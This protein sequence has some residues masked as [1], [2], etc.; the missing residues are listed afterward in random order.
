MTTPPAVAINVSMKVKR[1]PSK[2]RYGSERRMTFQSKLENII[3]PSVRRRRLT[4]A[5]EPRYRDAPFEPAHPVY[6]NDV[7]D[8]E[9]F[10]GQWRKND[11]KCHR[12]KDVTVCLRQRQAHGESGHALPAAQAENSGFDLF[13]NACRRVETEADHRVVERSIG[14]LL[15]PVTYR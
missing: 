7:D 8:I 2:N 5:D 12:Q 14:R 13:G 4:H 6:D 3:S 9:K 15:E 1:I 10:R 11:A